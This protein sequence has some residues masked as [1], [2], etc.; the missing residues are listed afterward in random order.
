[1]NTLR[2]TLLCLSVTSL[3]GLAACGTPPAPMH[4]PMQTPMAMPMP[5]PAPAPALTRFSARL[6]GASEVPVVMGSADGMVEASLSPNSRVFTW[7]VSHTGLTGPVTA[8][9]FHGPAP[10]GQNA[11]VALPIVGPLTS[12]ISGGATLSPGQV[13][14]LMAGRWYVNVHTAANPNGEIRGQLS[15]RP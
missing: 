2:H 14:D 9:H 12:P 13:A 5:A 3:L 6:S 7:K 4:T 10:A 15:V 11:G 8:A 1:M